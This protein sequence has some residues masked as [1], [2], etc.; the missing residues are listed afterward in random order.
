[1]E[2]L[3]SPLQDEKHAITTNIVPVLSKLVSKNSL[4]VG[5]ELKLEGSFEGRL[6][7]LL[8]YSSSRQ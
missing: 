4:E 7:Q 3:P 1:M 6:V 2:Q 5:R 8:K